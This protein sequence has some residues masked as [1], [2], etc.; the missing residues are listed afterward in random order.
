MKSLINLLTKILAFFVPKRFGHFLTY[1]TV[2]YLFF[3]GLATI[4]SIGS[5][6]LFIYLGMAT[7]AANIASNILAIIFA[8][9]TNKIYVFESPGWGVKVLLSEIVKFGASRAFTTIVET[10]A[11][12]LLVDVMGFNEMIMKLITMIVIQVMGNYVLSKWIVFTDKDQA[13]Q[14]GGRT[15]R[16]NHEP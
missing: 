16:R 7:A 14:H 3:G 8:F 6:A 12:V 5:F 4:V 15:P 10:L 13:P 11:L 9:F 2:S 1:E